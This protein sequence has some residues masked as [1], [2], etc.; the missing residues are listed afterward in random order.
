MSVINFIN[1]ASCFWRILTYIVFLLTQIVLSY[2]FEIASLQKTYLQLQ[3]NCHDRRS[4]LLVLTDSNHK[5]KGII[6]RAERL[7]KSAQLVAAHAGYDMLLIKIIKNSSCLFDAIR[8]YGTEFQLNGRGQYDH[9]VVLLQK[10]QTN[11][12]NVKNIIIKK[13]AINDIPLLYLQ[14]HTN[15]I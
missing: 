7:K 15:E 2:S 11:N 12:I 5:L 13:D 10:L 9:L 6:H 8:K 4:S 1:N 3:K 14:V